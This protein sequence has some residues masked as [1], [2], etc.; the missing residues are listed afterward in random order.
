MKDVFARCLKKT[1]VQ[2]CIVTL[3]IMPIILYSHNWIFPF[4]GIGFAILIGVYFCRL[5]V[6]HD[7]HEFILE[8]GTIANSNNCNQ[9]CFSVC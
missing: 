2:V 4:Q 8:S 5:K 3:C 7:T 1:A 9:H 6:N